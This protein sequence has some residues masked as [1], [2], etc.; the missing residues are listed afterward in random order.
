MG[1][2]SRRVR[3]RETFQPAGVGP[4]PEKLMV[5]SIGEFGDDKGAV[6]QRFRSV[7]VLEQKTWLA[8]EWRDE[9]DAPRRSQ[10]RSK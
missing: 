9:V 10:Y 1:A 3:T 8:S 5:R 7:S 2:T 4:K 6:A